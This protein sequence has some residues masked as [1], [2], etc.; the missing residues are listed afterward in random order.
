MS[1]TTVHA[2]PAKVIGE[3]LGAVFRHHTGDSWRNTG[4]ARVTGK[5][6]CV[7]ADCPFDRHQQKGDNGNGYLD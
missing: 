2:A 5:R 6:L 7:G 1:V 3:G 4:N